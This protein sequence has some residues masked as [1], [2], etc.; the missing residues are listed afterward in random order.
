MS[1]FWKLEG[2]LGYTFT[3]FYIDSVNHYYKLVSLCEYLVV[4]FTFLPV[5]TLCSGLWWQK[6]FVAQLEIK[7]LKRK[8]GDGSEDD[9]EIEGAYFGEEEA[10]CA[11][12]VAHTEC[13]L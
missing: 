5:C 1:Q 11:A 4:L 3:N 10:S 8:S 2:S 9:K 12:D 6:L 13:S 7:E